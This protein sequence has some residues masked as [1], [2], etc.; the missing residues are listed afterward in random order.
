MIDDKIYYAEVVDHRKHMYD[1][2]EKVVDQFTRSEKL[3]R[4]FMFF[5]IIIFHFLIS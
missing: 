3:D 5:F 4:L 1:K 2:R